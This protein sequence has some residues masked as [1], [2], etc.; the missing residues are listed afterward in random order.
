[1]KVSIILVQYPEIANVDCRRRMV[2]SNGALSGE[3][4]NKQN[5]MNLFSDLGRILTQSLIRIIS[6]K[7]NIVRQSVVDA[8]FIDQAEDQSHDVNPT[9]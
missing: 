8:V 6:M 5:V 3:N 7:M 1:M 4:S 9:S 2:T